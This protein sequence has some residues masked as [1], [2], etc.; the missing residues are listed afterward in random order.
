MTSSYSPLTVQSGPKTVLTVDQ[1]RHLMGLVETKYPQYSAYYALALFAGLRP[2]GELPRLLTAINSE[3]TAKYI[4]H[5]H[6]LV[7]LPKCGDARRVP[8]SANLTKWLEVAGQNGFAI[9]SRRQQNKIAAEAGGLPQNVL[10][11]TA[12][13]AYVSMYESFA[14][15]AVTFGNSEA[16]IRKHYLSLMSR[17]EATAFYEIQPQSVGVTADLH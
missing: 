12:I 8:L 5:G 17:D 11:H 14:R 13:S 2:D 6:V 1:S 16:M 10:R 4:A 15:A 9:P 3:G 7:A